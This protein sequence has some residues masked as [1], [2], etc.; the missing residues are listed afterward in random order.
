MSV[1][2]NRGNNTPSASFGGRTNN[3]IGTLKDPIA[4]PKPDFEIDTART[5]TTEIIQ[6]NRGEFSNISNPFIVDIFCLIFLSL[7]IDKLLFNCIKF[8][9][10][11]LNQVTFI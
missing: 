2:K 10:V 3:I 9:P 1:S 5:A 4:P 7:S 6:K 8:L 11:R